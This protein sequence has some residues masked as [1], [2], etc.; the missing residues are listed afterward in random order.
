MSIIQYPSSKLRIHLQI[1]LAG[2]MLLGFAFS[3]SSLALSPTPL[4]Y[5][6]QVRSIEVSQFGM[7]HPVGLTYFPLADNFAVLEKPGLETTGTDSRVV[8]LF[9]PYEISAGKVELPFAITDPLNVSFDTQS[10]SLLFLDQ[11]NQELVQA[12][13]DERSGPSPSFHTTERFNIQTLGIRNPQGVAF[14]PRNGQLFILDAADPRIVQI[15]PDPVTKFDG[16]SAV[17]GDRITYIELEPLRGIPLR[18][19]AFNPQNGLLYLHSPEE[20]TLYEIDEKG[21]VLSLRDLSDIR[22]DD[23]QAMVFAPSGDPT[24]DPGSMSLYIADS[25]PGSEQASGDGQIVELS[26]TEPD[27]MDLP[28][29]NFVPYLIQVID[30]SLWNPPSPD[31]TGV[32]YFPSIGR[33]V[34]VD[35]EVEETAI[36]QGANVFVAT[37]SGNLD[38]TCSTITFSNE[39]TGV[40]INPN[41]NHLFFTD[42]NKDDVFEVDPGADGMYC[43]GDDTRTSFDTQAF[44]NFDPSGITY[45][46]GNLFIA[47]G[48]GSEVYIV[49]PGVNG[50]FVGV[51]P[52]GDDTVTQFDTS[53]L[54]LLD[55]EGIGYHP[56][57]GTLFIVSRADNGFMVETTTTGEVVNVFILSSVNIHAPSGLGIGPGSQNPFVSNIYITARG[58]DNNSDPNENDGKVYELSLDQPCSIAGAPLSTNS[59]SVDF[60]PSLALN[61]SLQNSPLQTETA[62]ATATE[63]AIATATETATATATHTHTPTTTNTP[64]PLPTCTPTPLP[65]DTPTPTAT[66]TTTPTPTATHTPSPTATHTPSPTATDTPTPTPTHTPTATA[67]PTCVMHVDSIDMTAVPQGGSQYRAEATVTILNNAGLPVSG[68]LV[69]GN[70]IG[71]SGGSDSGITDSNGQVTLASPNWLNGTSW[72]FCVNDVTKSG[73]IY[74]FAANVENCDSI[75]GEPTPTLTPTPTA[76]NTSM[77]TATNTPTS[78]ATHT[79]T[80]TATNTPS[81]TATTTPPTHKQYL[82]IIVRPPE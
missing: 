46:Q 75:G 38:T 54:G 64:T 30:T 53:V 20:K 50:I 18:G 43:T 14:D 29:S 19:I 22:L 44:N 52:A 65:S 60:S 3:K 8:S 31:P 55:P 47:D 7:S 80:P 35:S 4:G 2:L 72:A 69:T 63:T 32:D 39:P 17:Q 68:A 41:N 77:P 12:Q 13:V 34:I 27:R 5:L 33:L 48:L 25:G 67:C 78:T 28:A 15:T 6:F 26:L 82:P 21:S 51:P 70:F 10:S 66:R 36:W 61:G 9:D 74:D 81:P 16:K 11:A 1:W 57:R 45:G 23:P 37:L 73:W 49:S 59:D 42:D 40:A 24:D 58:V 71:D 56:S 79:P 76:T 62:T